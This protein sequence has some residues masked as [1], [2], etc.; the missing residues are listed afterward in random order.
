MRKVL[1]NLLIVLALGLCALC[2]YQ[3]YRESHLRRQSEVMSKEIFD[4][5]EAIQGLEDRL[6]RSEAEVL[7]LEDLKAQLTDTIKT[8]RQE[9][10]TLT[11]YSEKLE[12]DAE[13]LKTQVQAYKETVEQANASIRKQN[14][15]IKK[16]N[17]IIKQL[18][19]EK[20][21]VVMKYNEVVNQ[22]NDLVK[23]FEQY[24]KDVQSAQKQGEQKEQKK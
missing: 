17:E 8:N 24:Q 22:Y 2:T 15:D 10:A 1:E 16:Q 12:R 20:N 21:A 13:S 4:K 19:E 9:L 14:E 6:K 3:W 5:K 23:Q 7:R 18:S 11:K